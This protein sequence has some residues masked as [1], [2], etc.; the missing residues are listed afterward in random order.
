[1]KLF[2]AVGLA[3]FMTLA[4][5]AEISTPAPIL[6]GINLQKETRTNPPQQ[7][8][9]AIV[10]LKNPKLRLRVAG[11]GPDPDGPGKWQTTLMEPTRI[12][13]REN[14]DFVINGD[15]F[16]ARGVNDGEGTNSHFRAEQWALTEGV[17]M[18]DGRTW[19][20]AGSPR[21]ALIVRKDGTVSIEPIQS[22]RINDWQVISGNVLLVTN[23]QPVHHKNASRHPRTVAGM[24][25][26]GSHL[27]LL[28]VD[29][30][31]PGVAVGMTYNELSA[32]MIR[33]GC[34]T[35]MNLDG[36]GS[37]LMAFRDPQTGKM[38][39]LNRPTD[40]RERAVADV[41]GI[42]VEK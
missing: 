19:S 6:P 34:K 28:L 16:K 21:P 10:D 38:N 41:L 32:E 40:G 42:V 23:S 4:G 27:I 12:A 22:P 1:M 29:G 14:F 37:S 15:F 9:V 2:F 31:K 5:R 33:L 20:T 39:I 8:F 18:T 25:A 17:A 30:R 36:G 11:G 3:L 35:A 24:D 26:D 7:L 13:T